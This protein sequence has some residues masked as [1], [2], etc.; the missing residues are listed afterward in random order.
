MELG[1]PAL[2]DVS[3]VGEIDLARSVQLVSSTHLHHAVMTAECFARRLRT[4]SPGLP[5]LAPLYDFLLQ[6]SRPFFIFYVP[7][8][9][10]VSNA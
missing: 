1:V 9:R 3:L 6:P 7:L 10:K 2:E 8:L 5:L 4:C